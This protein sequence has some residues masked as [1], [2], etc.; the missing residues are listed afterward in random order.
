MGLVLRCLVLFQSKSKDES[1]RSSEDI[2]LAIPLGKGQDS[3]SEVLK[4]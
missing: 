3:V 2:K 1:F 4:H